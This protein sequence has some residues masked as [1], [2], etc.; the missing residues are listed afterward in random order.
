MSLTGAGA[1]ENRGGGFPLTGIATLT[2]PHVEAR[3]QNHQIYQNHR[4]TFVSVS[5][6]KK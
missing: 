5:G 4:I 1:A 6:M 3:H 2:F